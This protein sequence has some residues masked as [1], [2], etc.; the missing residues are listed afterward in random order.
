MLIHVDDPCSLKSIYI[1]ELSDSVRVNF[2]THGNNPASAW[3]TGSPCGWHS[4][5]FLF[6]FHIS[7]D[8]SIVVHDL[9]LQDPVSL[10][11][12]WVSD[13]Q[14][15]QVSKWQLWTR[16]PVLSIDRPATSPHA[17]Y[18]LAYGW[19][20]CEYIITCVMVEWTISAK[21]PPHG[22][23]PKLASDLLSCILH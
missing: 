12:W 15:G 5:D 2:A 21:P 7:Q 8:H 13:R 17:M 1:V 18:W 19:P 4:N 11:W 10:L 22:R 6:K 9:Q 16:T 14:V 23:I 20:S 3:C